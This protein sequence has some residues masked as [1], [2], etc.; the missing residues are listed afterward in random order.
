LVLRLVDLI[1]LF[2]APCLRSGGRAAG[3]AKEGARPAKTNTFMISTPKECKYSDQSEHRCFFWSYVNK[4]SQKIKLRAVF[5]QTIV[6]G[7]A[8]AA[9]TGD[10]KQERATRRQRQQTHREGA[11]LKTALYANPKST[12]RTSSHM[13]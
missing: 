7:A 1:R 13:V 12:G 2:P 9:V 8:A 3:R 4:P 11:V 10:R 6:T 5:F